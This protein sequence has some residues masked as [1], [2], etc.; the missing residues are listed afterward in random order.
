LV[1]DHLERRFYKENVGIAY[2]YC[3]LKE[4]STQST[5]TLLGSLVQQLVQ[6][7]SIIPSDLKTLHD[8]YAVNQKS[9]TFTECRQLLSS[10]LGGYPST[11]LVIDALDECED[12]TRSELCSQL[13]ALPESVYLLI[14]SRDI[15]E[16]KDQ[17]NASSRL[18]IRASGS[19][20]KMYLEARIDEIQ[21]FERLKQHLEKDPQL[22]PLIISTI[23][24]K[25][26]G[27]YVSSFR[28]NATSNLHFNLMFF[29]R[30]LLAQLHLDSLAKKHT[31]NEVR[32]AI[33]DL[34][35]SLKKTYD[36]VMDRISSQKN[37]ED[38][39]LGL[40]VLSWI[41][42]A[43]RPLTVAEMQHAMKIESDSKAIDERDLIPRDTLVS[44]CAGIVTIDEESNIIRLIHSTVQEYFLKERSIHFPGA[45]REI[46]NTCLTYLSFENFK[47][48]Y[49]KTDEALISLLEK[50]PLLDYAAR[51][52]GH[53]AREV[54][55]SVTKV[56][57]RFLKDTYRTS[58]S[59]QVIE[60]GLYRSNGFSQNP[61]NHVSGL[62]LCAYFGLH[63]LVKEML[64]SQLEVDI[65]EGRGQTPLLWAARQGQE[66]VARLLLDKGAIVDARG[67]W[68]QTPL[69]EAI[70]EGHEAAVRL[71]LDNGAQV[72]ASDKDG[73]TSL[74]VAANYGYKTI[75]HLLLENG[76]V[77]NAKDN[78][79][80]IPLYMAAW[81]GHE[82]V[83]GL[84]LENGATVDARDKDGWTSLRVSAEYGHKTIVQLLLK[85]GAIVDA[86]DNE[87]QTPLH[88][89]A[90]QGHE[91]VVRLLLDKGAEVDDKNSWGQTPL[92]V[93]VYGGNEAIV[94]L[95]LT[96]GAEVNNRDKD[97]QTPLWAAADQG[98]ES[99]AR[100]LI[101][102]KAAIDVKD[103]DGHTP[104]WAAAQGKHEAVVQLLQTIRV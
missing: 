15:P 49:C 103:K 44:V 19:D 14:T 80:Q 101:K 35:K 88:G 46:A 16:L 23:R 30:F 11:Y 31:S 29:F 33:R 96:K 61:R 91:A 92:A 67:K 48:G 52:W 97:G 63:L 1:V 20:I 6:R 68:G 26:K 39:R 64:K 9:A 41:S 32:I 65:K 25:A 27:M 4:Q 78:K 45:Q 75:V 89:A 54:E 93:A 79:D 43:K 76:A 38:A 58:L 56:A 90:L 13:Q 36:G 37:G 40:K 60:V 50:N 94:R 98:Y 81:K 77:V 99:I 2:L 104:L 7:S 24:E 100:L 85:N 57:L 70:W 8:A 102:K 47:N 84:L 21:K 10:Q 17:I 83:V 73:Q 69:I 28:F 95:L 71:L 87:G 59:F 82:A 53:H 86:K 22:R 3:S 5:Q 34:P 12:Q 18:E 62:H 51:N 72:D 66:T 55:E 74:W 42:Y